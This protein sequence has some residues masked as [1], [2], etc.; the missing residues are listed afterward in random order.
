MRIDCHV[1]ITLRISGVPS[2]DQLA[3]VGQA[4]TR[5]VAASLAEAERLLADRHGVGDGGVTVVRERYDPAREASDGY[6]VPSYDD[7]GAPAA[8]PVFGGTGFGAMLQDDAHEEVAA[9]I[10][11][12]IGRP[13]GKAGDGRAD[14]QADPARAEANL[15]HTHFRDDAER[16]SYAV[17]VF[18]AYQEAGGAGELFDLMTAYELRTR[19]GAAAGP[20]GPTTAVNPP[21]RASGSPSTSPAPHP[22]VDPVGH[23]ENRN[24]GKPPDGVRV[25]PF[26]GQARWRLV[27][28]APVTSQ[29][30]ETWLFVGAGRPAGF[31]LTAD[32][33]GGAA[34][35]PV[36]YLSWADF[37]SHHS[38]DSDEFMRTLLGVLTPHGQALAYRAMLSGDATDDEVAAWEAGQQEK[39]RRSAEYDRQFVPALGMT[40]GEAFARLPWG[41]YEVR[42][43]FVWIGIKSHG[44]PALVETCPLSS[45]EVF[46]RDMRFY[47]R[48]GLSVSQAVAAFN[49]Q[50]DYILGIE[51]AFAGTGAGYR[52][53]T[54]EA[55]ELES[56]S[57]LVGR[58]LAKAQGFLSTGDLALAKALSSPVSTVLRTEVVEQA[59]IGT[60]RRA[61]AAESASATGRALPPSGTAT[62]GRRIGFVTGQ[63]SPQAPADGARVP[64]AGQRPVAGFGR[65]LEPPVPLPAGREQPAEQTYTRLPPARQGSSGADTR[66]SGPVTSMSSG[67][68]QRR[69]GG[70]RPPQLTPEEFETWEPVPEEA[71]R[72]LPPPADPI[73]SLHFGERQD[74]RGT[75]TEADLHRLQHSVPY[76]QR[77]NNTIARVINDGGGQYTVVAR[78][79]EGSGVTVMKLTKREV[80]EQSISYDWNPPFE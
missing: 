15:Y 46:N 21:R 77:R 47:L 18:R 17:G 19:S 64:T 55:A 79:E 36:W 39:K 27:F 48:H 49:E 68:R 4:L 16:L 57:G 35:S 75:L 69:G 33:P 5:A 78:T 66:D 9:K 53:S 71:E 80:K 67:K 13:G 52:T 11:E 28:P 59:E 74:R 61:V 26:P 38:Q 72:T 3:A 58:R 56:E 7:E 31:G 62:P 22:G 41:P 60:V 23:A 65:D 43:E 24:A 76:L 40:R 50:W 32:Q 2:D 37:R 14:Y 73:D 6:A 8:V 54:G 51:L 30:V 34:P 25:F 70:K 20:A 29:E 63:A 12:V 45:N 44:S 42:G 10:R 1:P